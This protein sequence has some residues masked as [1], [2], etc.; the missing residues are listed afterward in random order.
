V[1]H[2]CRSS[3]GNT[4]MDLAPAYFDGDPKPITVAGAEK[5]YLVI[6]KDQKAWVIGMLVNARFVLIQVAVDRGADRGPHEVARRER[7]RTPDD[8]VLRYPTCRRGRSRPAR[9]ER[10][11][12]RGSVLAT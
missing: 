5:S 6:K 11:T 12:M 10:A 9:G 1:T 4:N 7:F 8:G 3:N 2:P